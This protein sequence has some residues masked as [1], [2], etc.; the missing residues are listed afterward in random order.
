MPQD[1]YETFA[2]IALTVFGLWLVVV[3]VRHAEWM[4][5][6]ARRRR[7]YGVSLHFVLPGMMAL[8]SLVDPSNETLWRLSFGV[9]GAVGAIAGP[10]Y[11]RGWLT[12]ITSALFAFVAVV[13]LA[14]ELP[15]DV[16]DLRGLRAESLLLTLIVVL[17][18]NIAWLL[19]FEPE[20]EAASLSRS[21][22]G[23]PDDRGP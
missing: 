23:R 19:L 6:P 11:D 20:E 13:A 4:H 12:W 22:D 1:F 18:L 15:E 8:L 2:P 21:L 10:I 16:F 9:L 5:S 3:Q 14:P 7:A 17:G